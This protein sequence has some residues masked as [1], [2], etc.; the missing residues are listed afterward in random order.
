MTDLTAY[1]LAAKQPLQD[2]KCKKKRKDLPVI[3]SH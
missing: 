2:P 1:D 3:V